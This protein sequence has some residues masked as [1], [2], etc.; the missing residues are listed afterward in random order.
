MKNVEVVV[1]TNRALKKKEYLPSCGEFSVLCIQDRVIV[2]RV[3]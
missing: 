1:C 3:V 2:E